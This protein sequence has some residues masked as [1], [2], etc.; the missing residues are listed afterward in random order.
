MRHAGQPMWFPFVRDYQGSPL[1]VHYAAHY[2]ECEQEFFPV[3]RGNQLL[4]LYNLS[5]KVSSQSQVSSL[6]AGIVVRS[7]FS[8]C[9]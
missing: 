1:L 3:E 2:A 9:S 6:Q 4:L 5:Y 8:C 7:G